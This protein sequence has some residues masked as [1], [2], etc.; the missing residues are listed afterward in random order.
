MHRAS[1]GL[2]YDLASGRPFTRDPIGNGFAFGDPE[3]FNATDLNLYA[4]AGNNPQSMVDPSGND[5]WLVN[6]GYSAEAGLVA[7]ASV[8]TGLYFQ[9]GGSAGFDIGMYDSFGAGGALPNASVT[10]DF[11]IG[12]ADQFAGDGDEVALGFATLGLTDPGNGN[13]LPNSI[14]LS[15]GLGA[16]IPGPGFHLFSTYTIENSFVKPFK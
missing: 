2:K 14:Q 15:A 6:L 12:P 5:G 9:F 8:S 11:G 16:P 3:T 1:G 7:G 4:Y 13:P 10:A